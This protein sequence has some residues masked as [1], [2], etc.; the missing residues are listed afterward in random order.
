MPCR[1]FGSKTAALRQETQELEDEQAQLQKE[2][3]R[4]EANI[5][6]SERSWQNVE[7]ETRQVVA[8]ADES[9]ARARAAEQDRHVLL[10]E[11]AEL[12]RP[13]P[14]D[15]PLY[16]E[17][18]SV[19]PPVD[20]SPVGHD[21][22]HDASESW[23]EAE[24]LMRAIAELRSEMEQSK[25]VAVDSNPKGEAHS[26]AAESAA[27][28]LRAEIAERRA[29]LVMAE[30]DGRRLAEEHQALLQE[31]APLNDWVEHV[32]HE[33]R[34][35]RDEHSELSQALSIESNERA[36]LRRDELSAVPLRQV[37]VDITQVGC[38]RE[39][40]CENIARKAVLLEE[41][42]A[43]RSRRT[44]LLVQASRFRQEARVHEEEMST[45]SDRS[46]VFMPGVYPVSRKSNSG[47]HSLAPVLSFATSPEQ[48]KGLVISSPKVL[49]GKKIDLPSSAHRHHHDLPSRVPAV[50]S[51]PPRSSPSPSLLRLMAAGRLQQP[52]RAEDD[53]R[54]DRQLLRAEPQPML[55]ELPSDSSSERE[56]VGVPTSYWESLDEDE[57]YE[58][59]QMRP[60]LDP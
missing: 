7:E 25:K 3:A 46:R 27:A 31:E 4:L 29:A 54:E 53:D 48:R 16:S 60:C 18:P 42:A 1:C 32:E 40:E 14:V 41:I 26:V 11:I 44:E 13:T 17:I 6:H 35:A 28:E 52:S 33:L 37:G 38:L 34:L 36:G 57:D 56:D 39:K 9:E 15:E 45:R 50:P 59:H 58:S 47:P 23:V 8:R 43:H 55:P 5:E 22:A 49:A 24:Q 12:T 30:E 10:E 51:A 20:G 21:V 19:P 2:A